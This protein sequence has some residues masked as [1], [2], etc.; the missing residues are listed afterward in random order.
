MA[1]KPLDK[2]TQ[3]SEQ[4][5]EHV[6]FRWY[7]LDIKNHNVVG[8]FLKNYLATAVVGA[9]AFALLSVYATLSL[10]FYS[11]RYYTPTLHRFLSL[12]PLLR[13]SR[14]TTGTATLNLESWHSGWA[15]KLSLFSPTI[16]PKIG[17]VV[18]FT[19]LS[20]T[21]FLNVHSKTTSW[22]KEEQVE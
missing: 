21:T 2:L 5:Q 13:I 22:L 17:H 3:L 12:C 6:H 14:W 15:L 4:I 8:A 11:H 16:S 7:D 19:Q 18:D 10:P 9:G 20:I 1:S